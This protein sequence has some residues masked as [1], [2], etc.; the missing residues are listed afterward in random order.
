MNPVLIMQEHP[1]LKDT[2]Y[3]VLNDLLTIATQ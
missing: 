3:G 1:T 2:A